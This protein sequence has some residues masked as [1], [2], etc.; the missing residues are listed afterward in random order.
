MPGCVDQPLLLARGDAGRCAAVGRIG[1]G[2]HFDEHQRAVAVLQDQVHLAGVAAGAGG[3]S[4]IPFQQPQARALQVRQ[5]RVLARQAG[6]GT[7]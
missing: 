5:R 6:F 3:D 2:A 7:L 1:A 4:I